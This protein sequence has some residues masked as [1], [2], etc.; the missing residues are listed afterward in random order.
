MSASI[1][2]AAP[3]PA[4][5]STFTFKHFAGSVYRGDLR[6]ELEREALLLL[7]AMELPRDL[8]VDA[9]QDVVEEFDDRH[10]RAEA[11]PH[12]A[13]FE[14]DDAGADDEEF[15]RDLAEFERAR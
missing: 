4:A 13:E 7:Q 8:A 10:L 1:I 14:A 5:G 3:L 9:G 11:A 12:R 2:S 6:R 15:L